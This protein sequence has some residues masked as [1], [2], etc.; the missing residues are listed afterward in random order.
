MKILALDCAT[1]TGWAFAV[2]S[3]IVESGIKSFA[4]QRGESN[5][6]LFMKFRKWLSDLIKAHQID[7]V[8]FEKAHFRGGAATEIGVGL[9]TRVQE[10]ASENNIEY[11]SYQALNIKKR[12]TGSGKASKDDM[13]AYATKVLNRPPIDDN[14]ADAVSIAMLAI[15]DYNITKE[16]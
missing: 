3:K 14:E 11:A 4:K 6:I 15:E 13:I 1:V 9:Q 5:G 10:I 12:I 16:K 7:L 2:D 8:V